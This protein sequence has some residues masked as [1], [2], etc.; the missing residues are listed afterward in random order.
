M[1]L[2]RHL[3]QVGDA[4]HLTVLAEPAQFLADD[5]RRRSADARIDFVEHH[6]ADLIESQRRH[7]DR[8]DAARYLTARGGCPG[9]ALTRNSTRSVPCGSGVD[10]SIFS[11]CASKRPPAMPSS[12]INAVT[13]APIFLAAFSRA[14]L[15]VAATAAY[16]VAAF[17]RARSNSINRSPAPR[18]SSSSRRSD[19]AYVVSE[20]AGTRC[21]RDNSCNFAICASA[22][23]RRSG[24]RSSSSR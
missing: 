22:S 7:F 6:A 3:R 20:F 10:F 15:N 16:S 17:A 24:S 9:F 1:A 8:D 13:S 12:D 11:N 19:S 4:Q 14:L 23:T 2:R 18:R 5:F 21:F